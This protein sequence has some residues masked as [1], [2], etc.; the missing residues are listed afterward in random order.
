MN[1]KVLRKMP[2]S[3]DDDEMKMEIEREFC[4]EVTIL[5]S[6]EKKKKA[7]FFLFCLGNTSRQHKR[8]IIGHQQISIII[9]GLA[10]QSHLA[11]QVL[12]NPQDTSN[13][14]LL[15]HLLRQFGIIKYCCIQLLSN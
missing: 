13:H 7:C 9:L 2:R 1:E 11:G 4:G 15:T 5:M 10:T 6:F 3:D 8:A 12:L 14:Y